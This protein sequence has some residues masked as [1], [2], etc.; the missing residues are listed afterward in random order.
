MIILES[1]K[2]WEDGKR[3]GAARY[4]LSYEEYRKQKDS[5]T[6]DM[7]ENNRMLFSEAADI[8][9]YFERNDKRGIK[10]L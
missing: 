9:R 2:I 10:A 8:G 3:W 4:A 5:V 7:E 1:D 6:C